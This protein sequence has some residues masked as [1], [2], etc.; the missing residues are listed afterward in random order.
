MALD[1]ETIQKERSA[2]PQFK[3]TG[4]VGKSTLTEHTEC[5]D[6]YT[7]QVNTGIE[8]IPFQYYAFNG[9]ICTSDPILDIAEHPFV[10]N[11]KVDL[12]LTQKE[13]HKMVSV[14]VLMV[15]ESRPLFSTNIA[16]G[17]SLLVVIGVTIG[18]VLYRKNKGNNNQS[19][20]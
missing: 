12:S 10:E 19:L 5:I 17:I 18:I 3:V 11:T 13:P 2:I 9:E 7:T 6:S 20:E 1:P 8:K 4:T 15:P 14:N 16:L